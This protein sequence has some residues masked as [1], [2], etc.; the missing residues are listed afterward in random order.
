MGEQLNLRWLKQA[1]ANGVSM[2][3]LLKLKNAPKEDEIKPTM[4]AWFRVITY[5]KQF[6][7]ELDERRFNEAFIRLARTCEWFPTPSELMR[8]MPQREMPERA[9]LEFK[10]DQ[11][12]IELQKS[13]IREMLRGMGYAR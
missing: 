7:Q 1:I 9:H 6:D 10:V 4:E 13:K 8:A 3:V 11:A 5:K 12:A 2:L